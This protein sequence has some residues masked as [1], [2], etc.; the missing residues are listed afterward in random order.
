MKT[1]LIGMMVAVFFIAENDVKAQDLV[2]ASG[3]EKI[4]ENGPVAA[5]KKRIFEFYAFS[6]QENLKKYD[7]QTI[8]EHFL[9]SD[10]AKKIELLNDVYTVK[11]PISPGNPTMKTSIRKPLVY[12]S[13]K[14]IERQLRKDVNKNTVS[15]ESA[16][17]LF[18]KVLDIAISIVND[19]TEEFEK[20]IKLS[21]T[22]ES[23]LELFSQRVQLKYID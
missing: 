15:V 11:T 23:L 7:I 14:K 9:G 19:H 12:T 6:Q 1:I 16:A 4:I 10:I 21:G 22:P 13:V 17:K 3:V 5:D 2:M 20:E 8:D 18:D